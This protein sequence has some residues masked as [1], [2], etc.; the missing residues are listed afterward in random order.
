MLS[1]D[2]DGY[3]AALTQ[4][5]ADPR[6]SA[7]E[8]RALATIAGDAENMG[9]NVGSGRTVRGGRMQFPAPY[10][11]EGVNDGRAK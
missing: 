3:R 10:A 6:W 8:R 7:A 9:A 4:A 2:A 1:Y 11:A 5:A